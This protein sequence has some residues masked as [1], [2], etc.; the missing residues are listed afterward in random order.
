MRRKNK[1]APPV[2]SIAVDTRE[3]LPYTFKTTKPNPADFCSHQVIRTTLRTGDYSLIDHESRITIERKQPEEIFHIV[4]KG[5]ARFEREL[6]RMDGYA[7]KAIVV[8]ATLAQL[9]NGSGFSQVPASAAVNSLL[10]WAVQY[11][12][13]VF[14]AGERAYG[15]VLTMRLLEKF[16]KWRIEK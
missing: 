14:F 10:S 9:A 6:V 1:P 2:L 13:H 5:R 11:D 7:Y 3:Q 4:G 12:V 15:E 8:E 16:A